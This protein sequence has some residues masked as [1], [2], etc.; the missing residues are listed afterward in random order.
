MDKRFAGIVLIALMAIGI[1]VV[2][3][4]L[5]RA[6]SGSASPA[7]HVRAPLRTGQCLAPLDGPTE[8]N[9]IV[10]LVPPV[11]CT[12][13]HSAEVILVGIIDPATFPRRPT[14]SDAAF[15]NGLL[16][17]QCDL[18][19][20][21]FLGWGTKNALPRIQVSFYSRLTVPGDLEWSLG[22][23]WYACE[24][25]PGVLDYPISYT[26]SAR[27]A[28]I[29]TPPSAFAN[30]SDGPG[31]MA[32]SCGQP[33]HAEQLTRTYTSKAG[34]AGDCTAL[35]GKIIGTADP[36]FHGQLAVLSRLAGGAAECWITTTSNQALTA[37]LINRGAG[38][39]PWA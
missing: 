34:T 6:Q 4:V 33:H 7:V 11:P 1:I 36:T 35:V 9:T 20:A 8:L 23:R 31:L 14:V 19:A 26:G 38:P 30:C 22:Q 25:M 17:Q 32:M 5:G 39:L 3:G 2:P 24:L 28:S 21:K 29:A 37:T 10:D 12:R 13:A 18:R 15:T 27:N 16:S